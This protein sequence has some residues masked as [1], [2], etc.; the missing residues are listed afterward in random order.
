MPYPAKTV[1]AS[2]RYGVH[3]ISGVLVLM[4]VLVAALMAG[5]MATVAA[6]GWWL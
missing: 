5:S 6:L 3:L 1:V 4:A 2:I